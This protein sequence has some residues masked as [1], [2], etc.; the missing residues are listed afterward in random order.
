MPT[1][2]L[3][4]F[5]NQCLDSNHL[6]SEPWRLAGVRGTLEVAFVW[7]AGST[8]LETPLRVSVTDP[9]VKVEKATASP[10]RRSLKGEPS[11]QWRERGKSDR[12][13]HSLCLPWGVEATQ[14]GAD[15]PKPQTLLQD[16]GLPGPGLMVKVPSKNTDNGNR[17]FLC[18][19]PWA[20]HFLFTAFLIPQSNPIRQ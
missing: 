15:S 10:V 2:L 6:P 18:A 12:G 4:E 11:G 17:F 13:N 7:K 16:E 9:A 20:K 5:Y 1:E 8:Q 19:R 3:T 14:C